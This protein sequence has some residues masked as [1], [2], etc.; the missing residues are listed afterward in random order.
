MA[1][2]PPSPGA[3]RRYT[4]AC[5]NCGAPV[6]FRSA[7]APFA[8]CSF[9]RSMVVRA[10]DQLR[11]IGE[12][13]EV[14]DDHSPLQLGANGRYQGAPFTLVGRLQYR[15]ADG[16]WNEWHAL[17]ES[18]P[19]GTRSGW[20]SEDNGR[21]VVAFDA[22][23]R[24]PV[25]PPEQLQPGAPLTVNDER[26]TVASVTTAML[27][28][29]QGELP[30][31]PVLDKAFVV[32]DL[33][34]S[35]NDVGTLDYTEPS[36]PTWSV[37]QSVE[38]VAL[39]MQGLAEGAEKASGGRTLACPNCGAALN[40]KLDSTQTIVCDQCKS[41]V[42]LSGG[43]GG[44]LAHYRQNVP[45]EPQ[46]PLGTVGTLAL[47]SA[48]ELPWQ[49]VGFAA[50]REI[51]QD[52]EDDA[53]SWREYLLYNRT[54]GFAF[55]V[56]AQDGW[57]SAIPLTGAPDV[58]GDTASWQGSTYR[59]LYDYQSTVQFVLGEF[60]WRVRRDDRTAHTDYQGTG[61]AASRKLNR[62]RTRGEGVE[63]VVWSGGE[64]VPSAR[65]VSA[66]R[67]APDAA[68]QITRDASPNSLSAKGWKSQLVIA[69]IVLLVIVMMWRCTSDASVGDCNA[70]LSTFGEASQEYQTCLNQQRSG[71]V[72]RSG[73]GAFGGFSSGGSHK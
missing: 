58:R 64:A 61:S 55:L 52:A 14:F 36:R 26:W 2:P 53:G 29:A 33:R 37:G 60:Y 23:L 5:P 45:Y 15:Y 27:S 39:A 68:A 8:V 24:T 25:P 73:G 11:K 34:S 16:T 41:V 63:E 49:V 18:G 62:E 48:S 40:V 47:G 9:C 71:G 69:V 54:A 28:A 38:L 32:A 1:T 7:S 30:T 12:S 10:G 70:V 31:R 42:D 35:R 67:L 65:I 19:D 56:D 13:A 72:I 57:S 43:I 4:A 20:L 22:P 66:F 3:Q 6:E 21:Y 51:P 44:D 59:K 46:I 50:K 17:F